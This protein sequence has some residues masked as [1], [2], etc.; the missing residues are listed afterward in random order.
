LISKLTVEDRKISVLIDEST[1][2]GKQSTLIVYIKTF[3]DEKEEIIF[4]DLI[5]LE[6]QKAETITTQV[7]N[8]LYSYGLTQSHLKRNLICFACDGASVM[9]GRTSVVG[10]YFRINCN[11][12][13]LL[14]GIVSIIDWS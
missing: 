6:I 11:N 14:F 8:C 1:T 3:L 5:A 7:L 12:R 9:V 4:L 10:K 13:I 2:L